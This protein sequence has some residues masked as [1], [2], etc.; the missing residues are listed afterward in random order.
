MAESE[1]NLNVLVVENVSVDEEVC[2]GLVDGHH[3][4]AF[5]IHQQVFNLTQTRLVHE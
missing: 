1:G 5:P 2:K 4:H 3:Y